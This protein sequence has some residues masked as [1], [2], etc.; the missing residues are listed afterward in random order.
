ME[1]IY[2]IYKN[3]KKRKTNKCNIQDY[4]HLTEEVQKHPC[5]YDK[6]NKV[7]KEREKERPEGKCLENS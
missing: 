7:Y 4:E 3:E 1:A 6:V 2:S 5:L